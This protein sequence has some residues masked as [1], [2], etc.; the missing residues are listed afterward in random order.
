[1]QYGFRM[2]QPMNWRKKKATPKAAAIAA[3]K[4]SA[5]TRNVKID[6]KY[7][8]PYRAFPPAK[9]K[10]K[11]NKMRLDLLMVE[12][13]LVE[14][15]HVAEAMILAGEVKVNGFPALKSGHAYPKD[16][17]ITMATPPRF[18]SRAG[19]KLEAAMKIFN[20]DVKDMLC[21]DA[22]ASTGGFTDCLLQH[23]AAKV[24]AIDVGRGL[25]DPK[26]AANPRVCQIEGTNARFLEK[27]TD[28][29]SRIAADLSFISLKMILPVFIKW[30]P[31]E[32]GEVIVLIKPQFEASGREASLGRGVI[33]D[34]EVHKKVL[35][36][37]LNKAELLNYGVGGVILSPIVGKKG[38][39]K[40]FLAWLKYPGRTEGDLEEMIEKAVNSEPDGVNQE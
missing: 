4:K 22:G 6:G 17:V 40:E 35:S 5:Q 28:P 33:T 29:V 21:A 9:R 27:L 10:V 38:G 23:G 24:Y 12:K 20:W 37:I 1:M 18:V 30:L 32:G 19:E 39:N 11:N 14:S 36:E 16:A 25:L 13:D 2:R 3:A 34:P 7:T 26:I 15:R 8:T 31:P